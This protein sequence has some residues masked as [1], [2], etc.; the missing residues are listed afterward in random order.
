MTP[1]FPKTDLGRLIQ[2]PVQQSALCL[3]AALR[4][5]AVD[6]LMAAGFDRR[7]IDGLV[8]RDLVHSLLLQRRLTDDARVEVLALDRPG[9]R[10][11][12]ADLGVDPKSVPYSTRSSCKRS[13]MFLDHQLALSRFALMLAV[14]LRPE[15]GADE[16]R[17]SLPRL[18][19]FEH[20]PE[21]LADVV[22]HLAVD[23]EYRRQPLVADCLAVVDAGRGATGLLVE[24]D[25]GTESPSYLRRKYAGYFQWWRSGGPRRRF[26]V[27]SLR[28]LTIAPD[29]HRTEV[30]KTNCQAVTQGRAGGLFW[31]ASEAALVK[32]GLQ[33]SVW[34]NLRSGR[35]ALWS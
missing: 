28:L 5:V 22:H 3:L 11:V 6:D 7:A 21:R 34:S 20:D 8:E 19:S 35:L 17:R 26:D 13:V 4:F 9:A 23:G 18:L 14:A 32:H 2:L 1:V 12:A 25:R 27:P 10:L 33:S 24:I 29:E 16:S 15:S 30:L 31:F